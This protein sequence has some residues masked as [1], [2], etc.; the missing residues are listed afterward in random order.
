MKEGVGVSKAHADPL[1]CSVTPGAAAGRFERNHI[2]G[3]EAAAA[4]VAPAGCVFA[5][6]YCPTCRANRV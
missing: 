4:V 5:D 2:D 3:V 6:G 1:F